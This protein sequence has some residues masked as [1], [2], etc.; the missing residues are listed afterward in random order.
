MKK[1]RMFYEG[2]SHGYNH[3]ETAEE[4]VAASIRMN[5]NHLPSKFVVREVDTSP[6]RQRVSAKNIFGNPKGWLK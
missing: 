5:P 1:F 6:P 3:A 4:A 2:R